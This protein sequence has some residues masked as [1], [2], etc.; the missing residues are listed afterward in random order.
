MKWEAIPLNIDH[1]P[2]LPTEKER[3]ESHGGRVESYY[4]QIFIRKKI[5]IKK[6]INLLFRL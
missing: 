3:I 5:F 1:K 4:G 2:D 6:N